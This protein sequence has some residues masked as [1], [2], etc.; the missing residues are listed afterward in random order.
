MKNKDLFGGILI[1]VGTI[2]LLTLPS[3]LNLEQQFAV[4]LALGAGVVWLIDWG[5]KK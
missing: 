4:L 1:W 3:P 5:K 2:G